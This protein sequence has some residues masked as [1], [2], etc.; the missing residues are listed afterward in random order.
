MG[1]SEINHPTLGPMWTVPRAARFLQIS[2]TEMKRRIRN[3]EEG[4]VTWQRWPRAW[5][6]VTTASVAKAADR[7]FRE[8]P[9]AS[10]AE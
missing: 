4:F 8:R 10:P 6:Y 2:R 7:Y 1:K 9:P 3:P 5:E